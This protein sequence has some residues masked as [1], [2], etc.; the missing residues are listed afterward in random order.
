MQEVAADVSDNGAVS[1]FDAALVSQLSAQLLEHFF[2]AQNS[3]SDWAAAE[4]AGAAGSVRGFGHG[5]KLPR[6]GP[7]IQWPRDL[8]EQ[9]IGVLTEGLR[10]AILR[11]T[12]GAGADRGLGLP[13]GRPT[14]A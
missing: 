7:G 10:A 3:G 4:G 14:R 1:S 12:G 5:A 11:L 2:V 6:A 13:A 8:R 9:P